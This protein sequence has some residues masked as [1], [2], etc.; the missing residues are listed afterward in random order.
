MVKNKYLYFG[1]ILI[2]VI[3]FSAILLVNT[4][5]Q[6][7][8]IDDG[9]GGGGGYNPPPNPPPEAPPEYEPPAEEN[10]P[11]APLL[12]PITPNVDNDGKIILTWNDINC[13]HYKVFRSSDGSYYEKIENVCL[14][15][16][17]EDYLDIDGIYYYRVLAVDI[18]GDSEPSNEVSVI[19]DLF[20]EE[21]PIDPID[22]PPEEPVEDPEEFVDDDG[23]L[24]QQ[25][26]QNITNYGI[27][28]TIIV[29]LG[30][31]VGIGIYYK[32][33]MRK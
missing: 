23:L 2:A 12:N 15:N 30:I 8:V 11:Q 4:T 7:F 28:I 13:L 32:R 26:E 19:V 16:R 18:F 9:G 25:V 6:M 1:L 29:I 33:K 21:E 17:Y 10:P 31:L 20:D 22:P 3:S 14:D 5:P 24:E 27:I